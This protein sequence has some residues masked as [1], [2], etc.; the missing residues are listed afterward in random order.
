MRRIGELDSIRGLAA[1]AI[2]VL[3]IWMPT[4]GILGTA[5]N[6]FFVLSGY[7][8]TTILLKYAVTDRSCI[9]FYMRRFLRI[10]PIYYLS[11][12]FVVLINPFLP[13]PGSLQA[14]PYYLS[15]T[16]KL[17]TYWG[18]PDPAFI[19]AFR[20]TW[21]LAIEEQFYLLWPALLWLL[22]R[23]RLPLL[24][25]GFVGV[26]VWARTVG[27]NRWV[28][29]TNCD[30]LAL[31]GLL[32]SIFFEESPVDDGISRQRRTRGL[33]AIGAAACVCLGL[34]RTL[35]HVF[36]I[37]ITF[38]LAQSLRVLGMNLA[39]TLLVGLL[40]LNAGARQLALLRARPLVY[41]GLISYGVYLYHHIILFIWDDYAGSWGWVDGPGQRWLKAGLSVAV[42]MASWRYVE[43][44][45]LRLKDRFQYDEKF[46]KSRATTAVH[47]NA[48]L[49]L[50]TV[51]MGRS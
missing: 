42:A 38:D 11:L 29:A 3:H 25:M 18:Q 22:G 13:H 41:L 4:L 23:R 35:P 48:D 36:A 2:L 43:R 49:N 47:R 7:L 40:V 9:A 19:P 8:I 45:S 39:Y 32:A 1:I 44:P 34:G 51:E 12:A 46:A 37:P 31:G 27:F 30:G 24:A 10:A 14:F 15:Y 5:V 28:L 33:G 20:H 50:G 21:T 16:H 26:A 17:P 6:L